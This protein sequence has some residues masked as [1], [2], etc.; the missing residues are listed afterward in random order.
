L[1]HS[2][3]PLS[4]LKLICAEA[5][6]TGQTEISAPATLPVPIEDAKLCFN[7]GYM[8]QWLSI[9][10]LTKKIRRDRYAAIVSLIYR[11]S[12]RESAGTAVMMVRPS[13]MMPI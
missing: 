8:Y 10:R 2:L 7:A 1:Y 3:N 13:S 12:Q 5:Y 11:M 9:W 6:L 4:K